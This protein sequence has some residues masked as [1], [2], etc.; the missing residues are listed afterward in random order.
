[1][2]KNDI[3]IDRP[4]ETE[5]KV[6]EDLLNEAEKALRDSWQRRLKAILPAMLTFLI[7]LAKK[8]R[9]AATGIFK[10]DENSRLIDDIKGAFRHIP[11]KT[12]GVVIL[13]AGFLLAAYLIS[14]VYTVKPG[15]EAVSTIFGKQIRQS[16][17]EGLHYRLP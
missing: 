16:I 15:E 12:R 5:A 9:G 4:T 6:S 7:F 13:L 3:P 1:M 2:D 11:L 10:D 17:T 8:I 14:G